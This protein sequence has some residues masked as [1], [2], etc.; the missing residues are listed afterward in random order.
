[1]KYRIRKCF[2]SYEVQAYG[3]VMLD[4]VPDMDWHTIVTCYDEAEAQRV[5][6]SLQKS[7]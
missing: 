6:E 4:G 1:M 7:K 3:R 2:A 5:L